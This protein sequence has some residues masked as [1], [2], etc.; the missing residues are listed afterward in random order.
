MRLFQDN[1]VS[2]GTPLAP[3]GGFGLVGAG[4]GVHVGVSVSVG[5]GVSVGAG[6]SVSV[7][8]AVGVGLIVVKDQIG[9]G[10]CASGFLAT[11]CQK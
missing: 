4:G 9:P 3:S 7:G 5:V 8:V 1:C 10:V 2:M 6:V 11:T